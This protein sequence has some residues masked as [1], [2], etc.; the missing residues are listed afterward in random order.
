MSHVDAVNT[1]ENAYITDAVASFLL[2]MVYLFLMS[3]Q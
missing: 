3:T 2:Y 1:K